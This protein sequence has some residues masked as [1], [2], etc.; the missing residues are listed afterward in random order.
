M[1]HSSADRQQL[2]LAF[3]LNPRITVYNLT[4]ILAKRDPSLLAV[5]RVV[6]L[7]FDHPSP[8]Q[9]CCRVV[10]VLLFCRGLPLCSRKCSP[11][12]PHIRH[13]WRSPHSDS[14]RHTRLR[15]LFH[16]PCSLSRAVLA[17]PFPLFSCL[18]M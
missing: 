10:P 1:T 14:E 5:T 17:C 3:D 4:C 16:L 9:T 2:E 18:I 13:E 12:Q 11:Y 6:L 15:V 8:P 7:V